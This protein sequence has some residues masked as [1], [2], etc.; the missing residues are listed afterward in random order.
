MTEDAPRLNRRTV[1]LS[2]LA[3][4]MLWWLA[5]PP[6]GWA[7]LGFLAPIP[8][9]CLVGSRATLSPRD[10]RAIWLAGFTF[11]LAELYWLTLPYWATAFGWPVLAGYL[12][13]YWPALIWITRIANRR[14]RVPILVAFPLAWVGM[15]WLEANFLGGILMGALG[16]SQYQN[17]RLIQISDTLGAYG[18]SSLLTFFA[19]G[20][21]CLCYCCPPFRDRYRMPQLVGSVLLAAFSVA[22]TLGYG[23]MRLQNVKLTAGPRIALI[24]GSIDTEMKF[25][26][27]QHEKVF[28]EYL[29]LSQ[30]AVAQEPKP[31]LLVWPE[32]MF[33]YPLV[34]G[35]EGAPLPSG[36]TITLAQAEQQSRDN[37]HDIA[38]RLGVPLLLGMDSH[39]VHKNGDIDNANTAILV[40][41]RG[42]LLARYDKNHPVAFG[43]FTPLADWLPFLAAL[44]PIGKGITPGKGAEF[45]QLS[46]FSFSPSICYE[47]CVPHLIPNQLAQLEHR[48]SC[49]P[50]VLI[51]LTNDGWFWGS[52]ELDLH[53]ICGVFR[54]VE[55]RL[56]LAIAANTGFSAV[57]DPYGRIVCQGP[58]RD[59]KVLLQS[60]PLDP[61]HPRGVTGFF[62]AAACGWGFV[63]LL[64][65]GVYDWRQS[66]T[67]SS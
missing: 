22:A 38:T 15:E 4:A 46:D 56:P 3:T 64:A 2:A 14:W 30:A 61:T 20:I 59:R 47:T 43:E 48:T 34:F 27:T 57:I 45:M 28:E 19:A 6:I 32:T 18:V 37:L 49:R 53:L 62:W 10:Y 67:Q 29:S 25:D 11:W 55:N 31:D 23:A 51:N 66:R 60:I 50:Q 63:I 9:A 12:A 26:P 39:Y 65:V 17:I 33:R 44:S 40:S 7:W 42:E 13:A 36:S 54:A 5:L 16:H 52:S 35:E 8:L 24:Q 1:L 41:P 21:S 58:R